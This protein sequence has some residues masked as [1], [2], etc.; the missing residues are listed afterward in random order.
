MAYLRPYTETFAAGKWRLEANDMIKSLLELEI[1]Y[2][3]LLLSTIFQG[4]HILS[5]S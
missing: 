1:H 2:V 5:G 4:E 3:C